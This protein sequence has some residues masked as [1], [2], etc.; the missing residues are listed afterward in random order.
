MPLAAKTEGSTG[1]GRELAKYSSP[2][3]GPTMPSPTF[4][5]LLESWGTV[6]PSTSFA[7]SANLSSSRFKAQPQSLGD[8]LSETWHLLEAHSTLLFSSLGNPQRSFASAAQG[9]F[10]PTM[11]EID[12]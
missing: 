1:C 6:S 5:F 4:H 10:D 3:T 12:G 11:F 2:R 9:R 8:S 7:L